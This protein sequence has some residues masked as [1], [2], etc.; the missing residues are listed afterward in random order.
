MANIVVI[1]DEPAM[2]RIT[3]RTLQAAGHAVVAFANGRGGIEHFKKEA[4]DL[5]I[6]DIFMPEMEGLETIKS[7]RD[8]R[9]A[10]PIIAMSGMSFGGGDYLHVAER[11]GAIATLKKPFRRSELLAL[12]ARVLAP[13]HC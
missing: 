13:Q 8:L 10:M 3:C 6:T 4:P 7:A 2:L 11:F 9:P 12:V 5:L 1:D